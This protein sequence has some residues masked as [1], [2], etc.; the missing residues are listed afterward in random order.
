[1]AEQTHIDDL[2][3]FSS[4][5][6]NKL[7]N[8]KEVVGLIVDKNDPD[9]FGEDGENARDH[10]FD[11]DYI[12]ETVLQA[13]AYIMVDVDMTEASSGSI[14]DLEIY[15]QIVVSKKYMNLDPKKFAGIKGNRRDNLA[16]QV[17]LLL[18][19]S[20]DFGVGRLQL[21]SARTASVPQAFTSKMLV[22]RI[23]DFSKKRGFG[24][25]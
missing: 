24:E 15:V 18:N 23:P 12:D 16:R 13:G 6:I 4:D 19:G 9:L 3:D 7:I 1:M 2:I 20:R 22:Y 25:W 21:A 10:M 17:D 11:Y 14:N 8:S 5:V